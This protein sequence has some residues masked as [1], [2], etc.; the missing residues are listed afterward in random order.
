MLIIYVIRD[1][2]NGDENS[3]QLAVQS[4]SQRDAW[5][6]ARSVWTHLPPYDPSDEVR[7]QYFPREEFTIAEVRLIV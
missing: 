2:S 7:G 1:H 4:T 3:N 5:E 6:K